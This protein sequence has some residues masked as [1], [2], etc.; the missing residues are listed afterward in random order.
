MAP[1]LSFPKVVIFCVIN[2]H[3]FLDHCPKPIGLGASQIL[4]WGNGEEGCAQTNCCLWTESPNTG[5]TQELTQRVQSE[6]GDR[7]LLGK[8]SGLTEEVRSVSLES[9]QSD[10]V[11]SLQYDWELP[12]RWRRE[13]AHKYAIIKCPMLLTGDL[14]SLPQ[15]R[16]TSR[17]LDEEGVLI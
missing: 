6:G 12:V 8:T 10:G 13:T 2:L 3:C 14:G 15:R 5:A 4:P 1:F 11:H 17:S 9:P 7:A 16:G